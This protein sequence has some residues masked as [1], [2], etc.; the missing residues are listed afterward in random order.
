MKITGDFQGNLSEALV[1]AAI[2]ELMADGGPVEQS[3]EQSHEILRQYGQ[4][5]DYSVDSIIESLQEPEVERTANGFRIRWGWAAEHAPYFEWGTS[6]HVVEGDPILS[7]VWDSADAPAWV[8]E[9]FEAEG[10]GYRVFFPQ[11]EPS[12]LPEARFA[13]SVLDYL[14]AEVAR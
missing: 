12:G 5:N 4:R 11:T 3:I 2:E 1:D 8:A 6:D 10:D 7:F 9:E 13:R 14:R